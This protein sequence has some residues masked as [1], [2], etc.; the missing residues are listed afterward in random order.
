MRAIGRISYGLYLWHLPLFLVID[1]ERTGLSFWPL[2]AVR[3]AATFAAAGASYVLVER[4]ALRWKRR[5]EHVPSGRPPGHD[6][7]DPQGTGVTVRP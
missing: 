3:F 4:P 7:P 6:A 1:A 5:F 2:L